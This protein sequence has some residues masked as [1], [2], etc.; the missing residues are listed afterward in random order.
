MDLGFMIHFLDSSETIE[1]QRM[2][3]SLKRPTTSWC[4][5]VL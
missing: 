2:Y 5:S 1:K 3:L 4:D